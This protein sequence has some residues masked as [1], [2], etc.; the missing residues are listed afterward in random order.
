MSRLYV[1]IDRETADRLRNVA[2]KNRRRPQDEAAVILETVLR[3]DAHPHQDAPKSENRSDWS[4]PT[5]Q[6]LESIRDRLGEADS[7]SY[8]D[9]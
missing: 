5:E 8:G 1:P 9:T 7:C 3:A 2:N 6:E 4:S